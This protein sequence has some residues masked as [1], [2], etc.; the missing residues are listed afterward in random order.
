MHSVTLES[1]ERVCKALNISL[2]DFFGDFE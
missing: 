2:S 1:I